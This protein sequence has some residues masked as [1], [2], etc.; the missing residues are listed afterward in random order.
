MLLSQMQLPIIDTSSYS[1]VTRYYTLHITNIS[2]WLRITFMLS[3]L[4]NVL[5]ERL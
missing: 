1:T 3:L 2:L 4:Y 5:Q